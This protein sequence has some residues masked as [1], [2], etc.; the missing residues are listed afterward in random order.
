MKHLVLCP[1]CHGNWLS[2]L[3]VSGKMCR[4]CGGSSKVDNEKAEQVKAE[5]TQKVYI[6]LFNL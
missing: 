5:I 4:G 6:D 1:I 3:K 2:V